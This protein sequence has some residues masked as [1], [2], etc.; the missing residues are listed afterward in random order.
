MIIDLK[1]QVAETV[2]E[3]LRI[4]CRTLQEEGSH[5]PTAVLH[6]LGGMIPIVLPFEDDDQKRA[7]VDLVK[8]KALEKGAYAVTTI[9]CA[10]IVDSRTGNEEESLILATSI[11]RGRPYVVVQP[12]SRDADRRVIGF[13]ETI[14]GE[15][16][17]MPGQMMIFPD[18]EAETSH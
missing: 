9:T 11:Q 12:Y 18:W 16:A 3:I 6:T 15:R 1:S 4:A 14:E 2:R 17:A 8:E 10:R 7:L 13:G 5:L